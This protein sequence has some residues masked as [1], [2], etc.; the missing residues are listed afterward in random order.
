MKINKLNIFFVFFLI[1]TYKCI[2]VIPFKTF[3]NKEPENFNG[4]DVIYY[5]GKNIIYS[6]SL[7]GTPP[8]KVSYI[9]ESEDFETNLYQHMCDV[10]DSLYD[11]EKSET[12]YIEKVINSHGFMKNASRINETLYFYDNLNQKELKPFTNYKLVYSDNEKKVQGDLYEYHDYTC[13]NIG[14]LLKYSNYGEDDY[15]II[16]QLKKSYQK[17]ETYDFSFKYKSDTEGVIVIG[18]EPHI[19]D[20]ENYYE[21]QYRIV[22]AMGTNIHNLF[23]YDFY[24]NFDRV[25]FSYFNYSTRVE[26]ERDVNVEMGVRVKFDMGVIAG[27]RDYEKS[28]RE[29]FFNKLFSDN[30]CF[31]EDVIDKQYNYHFHVFSCDKKSAQDIIKIEFPTLYFEMKQFNKIFEL[32]YKDLFREKNGKIYF[33][34]YFKQNDYFADYFIIGKIFLKKYFFTFNQDTKMIGYYNEDL[35]GGKKDEVSS[36]ILSFI[37][38][39]YLIIIV[40]VLFV[41]FGIVGFFFGKAVYDTVRKKRV[42]ELEDDDYDYVPEDNN[43]LNNNTELGINESK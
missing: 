15:N 37:K 39:E 18:A 33:L 14:F 1:S 4:T 25:Y 3:I 35:P 40:S 26:Q 5:W 16:N 13:V 22:A 28:I 36:K 31:I 8:Q 42:N 23:N 19:Y 34:V 38:N 7:I 9:I 12:F 24:L 41:I 11:K 2:I 17:I 21:M 27:P 29:V 30:I 10:S 6:D 20:P 32:T 43:N